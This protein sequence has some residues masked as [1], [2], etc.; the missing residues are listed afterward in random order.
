MEDLEISGD[1]ADRGVLNDARIA[2]EF[3][4]ADKD[5]EKIVDPVGGPLSFAMTGVISGPP[6]EACSWELTAD[7]DLLDGIVIVSERLLRGDVRLSEASSLES[8]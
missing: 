2:N 7:E 5:G 3:P 1:V 8:D 4:R 6:A